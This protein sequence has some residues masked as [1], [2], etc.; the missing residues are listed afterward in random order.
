MGAITPVKPIYFRPFIGVITPFMTS[1]GPTLYI[2]KILYIIYH[3]MYTP[4]NTSP[5]FA[6][7]LC[8]PIALFF[9]W[10]V[11]PHSC[12]RK[13]RQSP[14]ETSRRP[15]QEK[16]NEIHIAMSASKNRGTPKWM[17][18]NGKPYSNGWF[19][20]TIIFGNIHIWSVY[21]DLPCHNTVSWLVNLPPPDVPPQK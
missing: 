10:L 14:N 20:G 9:V 21:P 13:S 1:K 12:D 19:G 18:Y 15:P 4:Q 8:D 2:V 6:S 3:I 5:T 16:L 17:V 11:P 7:S